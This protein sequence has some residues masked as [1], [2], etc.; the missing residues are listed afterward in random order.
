MFVADWPQLEILRL[1]NKFK[2]LM[3]WRVL[4][5]SMS[6]SGRDQSYPKMWTRIL[7]LRTW[8]WSIYW[9]CINVINQKE[10]SIAPPI[11]Y[12]FLGDIKHL[13]MK[14]N[15]SWLETT[16]YNC[17]IPSNG[18]KSVCRKVSGENVSPQESLWRKSQSPGEKLVSRKVSGGKSGTR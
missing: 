10:K 5:I 17:Y 16:R 14:L 13:K 3:R 15:Y 8:H 12:D 1:K 2:T 11:T 9:S 7:V 18:E 4:V 6:V